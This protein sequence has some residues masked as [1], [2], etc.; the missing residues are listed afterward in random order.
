MIRSIEDRQKR[1]IAI[2][3]LV[4]V[5]MIMIQV[6][7]GGITRL[8][9]SGLSITEW[10]PI[11]GTIPPLNQD[12][13]L[14]AFHKYQLTPQYQILNSD[15]TLSEFKNIFFWEWFHRVWARFLGIV[16]LIPF[17]F[18]LVKKWFT[19]EMTR[20]MI[21]LF[22]LGA[23]QGLV[24]W[25]MVASGLKGDRVSVVH[26]N[27][28]AHFISAMVLLCYTLWFAMTLL[29]NENQ[30]TYAPKFRRYTLI[31]LVVLGIQLFYGAFM[32][33]LHAALAANT[34]PGVNGQ[35]FPTIFI[36]DDPWWYAI[37]SS[38]IN[39]QW[40]H[41]GLAYVLAILLVVWWWK[42]RNTAKSLPLA[43]FAIV[44][45]ILVLVQII[46]GILTV[47]LSTTNIPVTWAVLHQ[48]NGM[49]LLMAIFIGYFL[50]TK[51]ATTELTK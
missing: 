51:K 44:P 41:R 18:F 2:W 17:A 5:F 7:L 42:A 19:R 35:F 47:L 11:M 21:I 31:V 38:R 6:L 30:K 40:I 16:F 23:L 46:L 49:L 45:F 36:G 34:W 12:D 14:V 43:R 48:F 4:G 27:L 8:T 29:F 1:I 39:V 28:A 9:G 3:L 24:G 13:W 32:A 22:L 10:A 37:S 25:I 33:G 15:F 26:Y 50:V 20:P